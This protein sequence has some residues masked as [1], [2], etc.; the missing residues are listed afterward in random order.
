MHFL[1]EQ[2][3]K[4]GL[5]LYQKNIEI[6]LQSNVSSYG[7]DAYQTL[8]NKPIRRLI[9][10]PFDGNAAG[11]QALPPYEAFTYTTKPQ[12]PTGN[13][14]APIEAIDGAY[15]RLVNMKNQQVRDDTPLSYFKNDTTLISDKC[16]FP[17][18]PRMDFTQS[19]I[20]YPNLNIVTPNVGL[21]LMLVFEYWD[22]YLETA[23]L[24][25]ST[26]GGFPI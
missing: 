8:N 17:D 25:E 2:Y 3:Y 13:S 10:P 23:T 16:F 20:F 5:R 9:V 26:D 15:I 18:Q 19:K 6:Q 1:D 22:V 24:K 11:M 14:F 7:L 21:S 4:K 12:S